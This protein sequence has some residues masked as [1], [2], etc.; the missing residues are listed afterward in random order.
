MRTNRLPQPSFE[1]KHEIND[2]ALPMII[3]SHVHVWSDGSEKYPWRP[4]FGETPTGSATAEKLFELQDPLGVT[5]AVA[6]QPSCYGP[7]HSYL[8][9]AVTAH[10]ERLVGI[11]LA[12]PRNPNM[13]EN[14]EMLCMGELI[15][16]VRL[17]A[18]MDP[19]PSWL[20]DPATDPIWEK[21]NELDVPVTLL[22]KPRNYD[23]A[24]RMVRRHSET[25]VV[26]DHFGRCSAN[27]GSP[28]PS[29]RR[30]LEFGRY[31]HV[32]MKASAFP[33]ASNE[34]FPY[35]DVHIWVRMALNA[36]G[37]D[38]LMWG[39]DYPHIVDQCGY[40]RGLAVV[41]EEMP[42]L[43]DDVKEWLLS[44]TAERLWTWTVTKSG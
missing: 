26:I 41:A 6:V 35:G 18:M 34:D 38:R 23:A 28:Y 36:F 43:T 11:A 19:D 29:Y 3:D 17:N 27:E 32:F 4:V 2:C 24:E 21:C 16:G 10:P 12:A 22:I 13:A 1:E 7:D 37:K 42:W 33:V 20:D 15:Q 31:E 9:D 14:L 5:R 8:L 30:L 39:T 25:K 44:R 40:D